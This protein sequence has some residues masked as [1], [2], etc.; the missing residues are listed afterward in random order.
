M[1]NIDLTIQKTK[2]THM[3]IWVSQ[4]STALFESQELKKIFEAGY[5]LKFKIYAQTAF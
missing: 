1:N 4:L 2:E 5:V 3:K